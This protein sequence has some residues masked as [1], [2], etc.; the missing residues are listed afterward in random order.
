MIGYA[1]RSSLA[2][3]LVASLVLSACQYLPWN[4]ESEFCEPPG[5]KSM[6]HTEAVF[7]YFQHI[8]P[9]SAERVAHE[10]RRVEERYSHTH[11]RMDR[12]RLA[13]LL[14][15]PGTRLQDQDRALFLLEDY[16][17]KEKGTDIELRNLADY[18]KTVI[19]QQKQ[20]NQRILA[21]ESQL[22]RDQETNRILAL[23]SEL[24]KRLKL[25]QERAV[26]AELRTHELEKQLSK[27]RRRAKQLQQQLDALEN[28]ERA[29]ETRKKPERI[30]L[31][32]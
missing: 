30:L 14:S 11:T 27:S 3:V 24:K 26:A 5:E 16:L 8:K 31:P 9:L 28:I 23:D 4:G 18:L 17:S 10:L 13:V 32:E 19:A 12:F 20:Q 29:I 1:L 22:A 6:S 2:A 21:L 25:Q 15:L 7:C